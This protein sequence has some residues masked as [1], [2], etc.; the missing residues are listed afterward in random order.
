MI[1]TMKAIY[2]FYTNK[3]TIIQFSVA[4]NVNEKSMIQHILGK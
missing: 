4:E 3:I 1:L 2:S